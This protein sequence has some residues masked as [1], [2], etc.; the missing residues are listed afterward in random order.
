[1]EWRGALPRVEFW[2]LCIALLP[3]AGRGAASGLAGMDSD[4]FDLMTS[5]RAA[6]TLHLMP[7]E[8][9]RSVSSIWGGGMIE[10]TLEADVLVAGGGSAG[11]SAALAAARSGARTVL[12][13]GRPVLGG[14]LLPTTV[15]YRTAIHYNP[16]LTAHHSLPLSTVLS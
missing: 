16:P 7:G 13:N 9:P 3:D 15:A 12:V 8:R 4:D 14:T 5:S 2:I 11:T 6:Q 10:E 1:M